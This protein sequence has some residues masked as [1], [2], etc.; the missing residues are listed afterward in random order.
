MVIAYAPSGLTF[1]PV[2]KVSGQGANRF[3]HGQGH[4]TKMDYILLKYAFDYNIFCLVDT[5]IVTQL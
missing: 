1:T 5:P 4:L 3:D 2:V